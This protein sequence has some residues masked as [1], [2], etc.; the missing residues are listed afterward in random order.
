MDVYSHLNQNILKMIMIGHLSVSVQK[1]FSK[2]WR[3]W[4]VGQEICEKCCT[5]ILRP[6]TNSVPYAICKLKDLRRIQW[7]V[8]TYCPMRDLHSSTLYI[9]QAITVVKCNMQL[10]QHCIDRAAVQWGLSLQDGWADLHMR[11]SIQKSITP[12][13]QQNLYAPQKTIYLIHA[14]CEP[15]LLKLWLAH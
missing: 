9:R 12:P 3:V 13:T 2:V 6:S 15:F 7:T 1:M 5:S 11:R 4:C 10:W 14:K 8:Q